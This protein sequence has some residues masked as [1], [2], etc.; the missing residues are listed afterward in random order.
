MATF[1]KIGDDIRARWTELFG[2]QFQRSIQLDDYSCGA[3]CALMVLRHFGDATSMSQ[4][5]VELGTTKT[6]TSPTAIQRVLRARGMRVGLRPRLKIAELVNALE[7]GK[8][9]IVYLD[10]EHYGVAYHASD[11]SIYL[12]DPSILRLVGREVPRAK[13]LRRWTSH[14]ALLVSP[15]SAAPESRRS[16]RSGK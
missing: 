7:E 2:P 1:W 8:L 9:A 4:L 16:R 3:H 11:S 13:F 12:A 15:R 6:G 10:E 14:W 5:K